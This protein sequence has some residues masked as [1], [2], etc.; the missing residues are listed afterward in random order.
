MKAIIRSINCIFILFVCIFFIILYTHICLARDLGP[1]DIRVL[2]RAYKYMQKNKYN[3]AINILEGYRKKKRDVP[4]KILIY[5]A[6]AY[7]LQ[8]DYDLAIPI[9]ISLTKQNNKN[10]D[11][12]VM[13][14]SCYYAKKEYLKASKYFK[15]A[16][17][18]SQNREYLYN[19]AI[20]YYYSGEKLKAYNLLKSMI[21]LKENKY[22]WIK[23]Y[24]SILLDLK[25]YKE[26]LKY[27]IFLSNAPIKDKVQYQEIRV[28]L[29]IL[30]KR[31]NAAKNYLSVLLDNNPF[32]T[33]WWDYLINVYLNE[34]KYKDALA[35]LIIKGY[36]NPYTPKEE[37]LIADLFMQLDI[38]RDAVKFYA[39]LSDKQYKNIY[40][41]LA[42]CYLRLDNPEK[43][44]L[45]IEKELISKKTYK[46]YYL[47]GEILYRLKKF[48]DATYAFINAAK[49]KKRPYKAYL[50]AGYCAFYAKKYKL[51]R[52][53]LIKAG[54]DKKLK[55]QVIGLIKEIS[56]LSN[57]RINGKAVF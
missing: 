2:N 50:M 25:K 54:K 44:L 24:V 34:N 49:L 28:Q 12:Y 30:L 6:N 17:N 19:T 13:L 46:L 27:I 33:K 26:A 37:K 40:F 38:P 42:Q 5:L 18:I 29:Y 45:Y 8:K 4:D 43:A 31:F 10:I 57:A 55:K 1:Q 14:A 21:L 32:N 15:M 9:L 3:E 35:T 20:C 23:T 7:V 52:R 48:D 47:K 56:I 11:V 53:Y 16:Y 39:K 22:E 41:T 51:A 36:I